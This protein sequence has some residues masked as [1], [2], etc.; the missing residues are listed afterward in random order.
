MKVWVK[1]LIGTLLA[2]LGFQACEPSTVIEEPKMYGP[3]PDNWEDIRE[4]YGCPYAVYKFNGEVTDVEGNPIEG[5]RMVVLP[6]GREHLDWGPVDT[7]YTGA[8]GKVA[9]TLSN[10]MPGHDAMEVEIADVDGEEHGSFQGKVLGPTELN[11]V[12]TAKGDG[13]WNEGEFTVTAK[14]VLEK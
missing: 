7:L 14:A 13:N 2:L 11:V 4:E 5:I 9:A 8:D 12:Q 10:D 1:S 6:Y 3:G